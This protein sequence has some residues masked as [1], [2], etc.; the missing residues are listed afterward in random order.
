VAAALAAY[1]S[2]IISPRLP[3]LERLPGLQRR[4]IRIGADSPVA[5]KTLAEADLAGRSEAVVVGQWSRSRLDT[6]CSSAMR[7]QPGAILE[8]VGSEESLARAEQMIG[9]CY[10]R[11]RGP[12]V[13]A[14]FGEVGRKV[15]QLLTDAGEDVRVV[16][17]EPRAN[18]DVA[19]NVLDPA[20]LERAGIAQA[21]AVVLA[22][23]SD[24]ATLFA[25]VIVRDLANDV[26]VIARVNHARNLENMHRAGADYALSISDV[27]GEMLSAPLLGRSVRARDE[28]RSVV[29][30]T[31]SRFAG[32][33]MA[34]IGSRIAGAAILAIERG[35]ARLP[36][37]EPQMRID[38]SDTLWLCATGHAARELS[39]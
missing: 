5:G 39:A 23:D 34:E 29:R 3:G 32:T 7:I 21:R 35:G 18:V 38:P 33:T 28:H 9:G 36:R 22:L 11:Q 37:F 12:F 24:D 10:L 2:D 6:N 31:G 27:S 1:A 4:E 25:T 17:R 16:E 20:V 13:V 19:G 15:H 30:V 26:R 14:G 8:L